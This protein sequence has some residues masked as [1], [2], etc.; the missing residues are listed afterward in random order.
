MFDKVSIGIELMSFD[1]KFTKDSIPKDLE[2]IK[3]KVRNLL[4]GIIMTK[5][6]N[7]FRIGSHLQHTMKAYAWQLEMQGLVVVDSVV[8]KNKAQIARILRGLELASG[9]VDDGFEDRIASIGPPSP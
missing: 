3:T 2:V 7:A 8:A 1:V 9:F 6:V 4:Q 5:D